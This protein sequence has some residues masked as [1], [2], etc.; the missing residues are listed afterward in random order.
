MTDAIERMEYMEY[1]LKR[2]WK[3]DDVDDAY[4]IAEPYIKAAMR[5]YEL[6]PEC[7]MC[8]GTELEDYA[9]PEVFVWT[10]KRCKCGLEFQEYFMPRE[11]LDWYYKEIYRL[12]VRPFNEGVTLDAV[13][14]ETDSGIK[15]LVRSEAKPRRHL[16]IGSSTGSFLRVMNVAYGCEVMGV[17]PGD[18]YRDYSNK[19]GIPTVKDISEVGGKFDFISLCHVLE[20]LINPMEVLAAVKDLLEDDGR[21][22]VEVPRDNHAFSHPLVFDEEMLVKMITTAGFAIV[23]KKTLHKVT[24]WRSKFARAEKWISVNAVKGT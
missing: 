14:G 8:G 19:R 22:Y 1:E 11:P 9:P 21:I 2:L 16:D 13:F 18:V 4:K 3:F 17:E 7:P 23:D 15:Y 6:V 5:F 10:Y 12:C 20:H 24:V